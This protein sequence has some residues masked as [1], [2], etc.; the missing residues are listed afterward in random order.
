MFT[1]MRVTVQKKI[2][3]VAIISFKPIHIF[4]VSSYE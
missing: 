3:N 4:T 2:E 1:V